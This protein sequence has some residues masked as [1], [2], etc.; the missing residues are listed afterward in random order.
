MGLD[1]IKDKL[2][3]RL[4]RKEDLKEVRRIEL[5]SFSDPWTRQMF[6]ALF[7]IAQTG[8]Y[9][10]SIK[11]RIM[12]FAIVLIEPYFAKSAPNKRAHMINLAVHPKYRRKRY[13]TD[14]VNEITK[15]VE[16][17][18]GESIYLEVRKSNEEALSFYSNL[19]F[20]RIGSIKDFYNDEDAIVMSKKI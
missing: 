2:E 8:F 5:L 1:H 16:K 3:I 14:L 15:D 18:H 10:A 6:E 4:S 13:G 17:Q 9:I 11:S 19:D 7:Q 12:G 20:L